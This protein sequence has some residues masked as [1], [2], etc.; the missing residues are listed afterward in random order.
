MKQNFVDILLPTE[1]AERCTQLI[2]RMKEGYNF[3]G[4]SPPILYSRR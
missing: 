1:S 3:N 2:F 4:C